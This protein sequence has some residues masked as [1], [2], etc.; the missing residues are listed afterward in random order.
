MLNYSSDILD[1]IDNLIKLTWPITREH[2]QQ[3]GEAF[4][5]SNSDQ[6]MKIIEEVTEYNKEVLKTRTDKA[7]WKALDQENLDILFA[8]L[9]LQH[10]TN[11][12]KGIDK[13]AMLRVLKKFEERGWLKFK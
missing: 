10:G 7:D 8:W 6:C 11:Q 5:W 13:F 4:D 2:L 9:T 1:A 3:H 12:N